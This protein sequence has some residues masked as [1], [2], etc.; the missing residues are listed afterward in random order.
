[1]LGIPLTTQIHRGDW[2]LDLNLFGDNVQAI[3]NQTRP[4]DTKR[5][6]S[7]MGQIGETELQKIIESYIQLI[8]KR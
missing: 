8:R 7:S 1:M 5:L 4:I 3:L 6:I 2:Y